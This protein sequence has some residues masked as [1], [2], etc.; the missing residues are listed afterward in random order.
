MVLVV[1]RGQVTGPRRLGLPAEATSFV[2]RTIEL[3]GITALLGTA[4]MVT[5][6]GPAGVGKTRL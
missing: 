6:I 2:G 1:S 4:R 3:A 5:V